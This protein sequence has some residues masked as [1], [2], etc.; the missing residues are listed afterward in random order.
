MKNEEHNLQVA[1][2][3][4][5]DMQYPS[6]K[7]MLFA[8]PNGGQ[9][10]VVVASKLKAEGVRAGVADL[11]LMCGLGQVLFIEMK[12][13]KGTQNES[14]KAFEKICIENGY[15]YEIARSFEDFKKLIEIYL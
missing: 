2:V 15:I 6:C 14:Q 13:K 5:F 10:N 12:T 8:V 1:C 4:W 3:R 7:N 9:R 11:I